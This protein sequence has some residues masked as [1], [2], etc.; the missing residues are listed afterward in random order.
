MRSR[1]GVWTRAESGRRN[2]DAAGLA[3]EM[4]ASFEDDNLESALGQ[5][6]GDR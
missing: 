2:L 4:V 5:F 6:M 3:P 1:V